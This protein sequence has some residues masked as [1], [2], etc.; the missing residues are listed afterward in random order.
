MLLEGVK[1]LHQVEIMESPWWCIPAGLVA[2]F[3]VGLGLATLLGI[4][5]D[6]SDIGFY[7]GIIVGAVCMTAIWVNTAGTI[8][9]GRYTYHVTIDESV[10][11]KEL[12]SRYDIVDQEGEIYILE[13]KNMSE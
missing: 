12:Y 3:V 9:T 6:W 4:I 8:H 10:D 13:D 11:F 7:I 2:F 1:I 5:T